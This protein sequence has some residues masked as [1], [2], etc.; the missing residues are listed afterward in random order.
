[1]LSISEDACCRFPPLPMCLQ[2]GRHFDTDTASFHR[3]S[4]DAQSYGHRSKQSFRGIWSN[5]SPAIL[6]CSRLTWCQLAEHGRGSVCDSAIEECV[7]VPSR[8]HVSPASICVRMR[9]LHEGMQLGSMAI[10]LGPD[11]KGFQSEQNGLV[12]GTR[13]PVYVI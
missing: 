2:H 3:P 4:C 12:L 1:M 13:A 11:L 9:A 10:S 5:I 8:A 6:Q 7:R